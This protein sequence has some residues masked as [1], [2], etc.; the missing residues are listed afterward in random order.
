MD[1][2]LYKKAVVQV[3][4]KSGFD[5]S[6]QNLYTAKPGQLIPIM[7]DELIPNSTVNLKAAI[8]AQLAPLASDTFMRCKLK[9]ATFFV[10]TRL[11]VCGYERWLT[12]VS[13]TGSDIVSMPLLKFEG[14]VTGIGWMDTMGPG[15]LLDHLGCKIRRSMSSK[16]TNQN[17][18]VV[19]ALPF[20]AYHRIYDDWFR[21]AL[22][23]NPV[24]KESSS[25]Y[26]YPTYYAE[27]AKF[28]PPT[29]GNNVINAGDSLADGVKICQL[30]QANFEIDMYTSCAPSAQNG[31]AQKV[32][33]GSNDGVNNTFTISQLRA[34]NSLQQFLERNNIAGNR[35]VD[36]VKAQYG[37][38]LSDGV[39][40]RPILLGSGS[41]DVYS[42]GI[43]NQS[44]DQYATDIKNPFSSV[45]AKFGSAFADGN[46]QLIDHF[47]ANEPGYLMVLAWL[48]PRVTYST[49]IDPILTR[50]QT[51]GNASIADMA[52][53]ILQNVGNE[54]LYSSYIQDSAVGQSWNQHVFG[55]NDRYATW[56]DKVDQLHGLLRDGEQ[57]KAF[58]LQRS[59]GTT[60]DQTYDQTLNSDFLKIPI[61]YLDQ[62]YAAEVQSAG[63]FGY[64]VDTFFDYKVSMPLAR[65][66]IPS[67]QDPAAEH[68]ESVVVN[69]RGTQLA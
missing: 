18:L 33:I 13:D 56:K 11:L 65:Y 34:A 61:N 49:G 17:P 53:P 6:H 51:S 28:V 4:R 26:P 12:G 67:L 35:I 31:K 40:Q 7:V 69:N 15:S 43:Y 54:P 60:T 25:D 10:P 20:L 3:Q 21:N 66:S 44:G 62:V 46:T 48:S 14:N 16:V 45:A 42:K 68:G 57:L 24:F 23:Q 58:A 32:Q 39:A 30:R 50:Y 36:Y 1:S 59:F 9:Y 55:Y 2:N 19:S 22:V 5:K 52:N 29:V 38:N 64:W 41:L 47:T 63:G 27:G 37:A 8:T